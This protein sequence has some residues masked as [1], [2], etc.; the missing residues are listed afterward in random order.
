[1]LNH[2]RELG[3]MPEPL[4]V[5]PSELVE[6]FDTAPLERI[7]GWAVEARGGSAAGVG[8]DDVRF[9]DYRPGAGY[10]KARFKDAEHEVIV[11]V[12]EGRIYSDQTRRDRWVEDLHSGVR[13]GPQ[14]TWLSDLTAGLLIALTANG[15]YLWL[16]PAWRSRARPRPADLADATT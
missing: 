5:A 6:R 8:A 9:L 14:G 11:D 12:Y 16:A 10:A 3:L 15:L 7:V 1:M 2:K 13:F 4:V